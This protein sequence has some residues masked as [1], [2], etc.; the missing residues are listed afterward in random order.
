MWQLTSI[1][2]INR[3]LFILPKFDAPHT[4]SQA[5]NMFIFG[6]F[7]CASKLPSYIPSP[8]YPLPLHYHICV[9]SWLPSFVAPFSP[10]LP[11]LIGLFGSSFRGGSL[12][13]LSNE[14]T[15]LNRT[16]FSFSSV[17]P[18]TPWPVV[19]CLP[20]S[21]TLAALRLAWE[22][23]AWETWWSEC[24]LPP[25]KIILSLPSLS[26]NFLPLPPGDPLWTLKRLLPQYFSPL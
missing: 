11:M 26:G 14:R 19:E 4:L 12:N 18:A 7:F 3:R 16:F 1:Y 8:S 9:L 2:T 25:L 10:S 21:S 22:G 20:H 13:F 5:W 15:C 6:L 24:H 17:L 23:W